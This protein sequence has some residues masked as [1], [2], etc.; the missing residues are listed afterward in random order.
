VERRKYP[1]I[2]IA[3]AIEVRAVGIK[4]PIVANLRNIA[5]GGC[6]LAARVDLSMGQAL[7]L[8]L[9]VAGAAPLVLEGNVVRSAAN[10]AEKI[11]QYGV[12]F[13]IDTAAMRDN[14]LT[15]IARYCQPKSA[16][17]EAKFAVTAA[18]PDVRPFHATAVAFGPEG[19]RLASDR[20]LRQEWTIRFDLKLPGGQIGAPPISV[21][22]RAKPGAKLLRGS[23]VQDI[24][25]VEPSLRAIA[26]IERAMNDVRKNARQAS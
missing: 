8:E 16:M 23:Y 15:Y 2:A 4:V 12:K 13:R 24:V 14:V 18:S 26:E 17:I 19:L 3:G 10:A 20:V 7:R 21:T 22:G 9:P 1:R 6:A 11:T 25:F 5:G